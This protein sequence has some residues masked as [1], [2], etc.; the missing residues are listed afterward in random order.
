[1]VNFTENPHFTCRLSHWHAFVLASKN[2]KP[3]EPKNTIAAIRIP[4]TMPLPLPHFHCRTVLHHFPLAHT[5]AHTFF[6]RGLYFTYFRFNA[7]P[8]LNQFCESQ[9]PK[10]SPWRNSNNTASSNASKHNEYVKT[11]EEPAL[12]FRSLS[13]ANP[14]AHCEFEI[15][16]ISLSSFR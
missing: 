15:H 10:N 6:L 3:S 11:S 16:T 2:L 13:S 8:K 14:L 12:T 4:Y 5:L 9:T 7:G 1:M